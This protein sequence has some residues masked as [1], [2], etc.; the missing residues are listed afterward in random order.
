MS[1]VL[2]GPR[3]RRIVVGLDGHDRSAITSD[4]LTETHLVTPAWA[5]NHLWQA[6]VVPSPVLAESTPGNRAV[7][8]PTPG[9]YTYTVTTFFPD[10]DWDYA[11]G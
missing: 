3:A 8:P 10:G 1:D 7:I 9:G 11:E 6:T 5:L 2:A 4:G